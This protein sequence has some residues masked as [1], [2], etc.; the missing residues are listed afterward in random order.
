M[1]LVPKELYG[2]CAVFSSL[3]QRTSVSLINICYVEAFLRLL[4]LYL[5]FFGSAS[6]FMRKA[7]RQTLQWHQQFSSL[8][9][10][11]HQRC[12]ILQQPWRATR[13]QI[14]YYAGDRSDDDLVVREYEQQGADKGTRR[15]VDSE[16]ELTKLKAHLKA[17][18]DRLDQELAEMKEGPF[19]PNSEFMQSLPESE[20]EAAIDTMRKTGQTFMHDPGGVDMDKID[21]E[22]KESEASAEQEDLERFNEIMEPEVILKPP[23]RDQIYVRAFNSAVKAFLHGAPSVEKSA[24][25]WKTYQRCRRHIPNFLGLVPSRAWKILWESQTEVMNSAS[26]VKLLAEDM[27]SQSLPLSSDQILTYIRSLSSIGEVSA[28]IEHWNNNRSVLGP[29]VE[30][31]PQFF[32]LGVQLYSDNDDPV[33]AQKLAFECLDHGTFADASILVPVIA[34]WARAKT[35][36]D[37]SLKA[38]TCY[39]R[40]K[41]ELGTS[42]RAQDY[43]TISS[44]LLS[45]NLP[46]MALAVFKD[47]L[48]DR[49]DA[50]SQHGSLSSFRTL[51]GQVQKMQSAAIT[52]RDVSKIS[53]AALTVLPRFLQNKYFF[54]SWIKNL[55]GRGEIEAAAQVVE[56]MYER[57]VRPDAKHLNGIV[58]AWFR[59]GRKESVQKAEQMAWAMINARIDFVHSRR[60]QQ[61]QEKIHGEHRN[62]KL[63]PLFIRRTVPSATI[64][65]FSILLLHYTRG[66]NE[67]ASAQLMDKMTREALIPPNSFIYNHWMYAA[68]RSHNIARVWSHYQDMKANRVRADLET[69]A[70]LWDTAK[71][72]WDRSKSAHFSLFPSARALFK[73]MVQWTVAS[74]KHFAV[75]KSDPA[76]THHDPPDFSHDLYD[77]IIRVFC[78]SNDLRGVLCALHGLEHF[79]KQDPDPDTTRIVVICIARLLPPD[80]PTE[81]STSGI[82]RLAA[83]RRGS[84]RRLGSMRNALAAVHNILQIVTDQRAVRLMEQEEATGDVDFQSHSESTSLSQSPPRLQQ[85]EQQNVAQRRQQPTPATEPT[86]PV[87]SD[88]AAALTP[89]PVDLIN[90]DPTVAKQ[91]RLDVLSDLIVVVLKQM[92]TWGNATTTTTTAATGKTTTPNP[93]VKKESQVLENNDPGGYLNDTVAS[94]DSEADEARRERALSATLHNEIHMVGQSMGLASPGTVHEGDGQPRRKY[95]DE[96]DDDGS[97]DAADRQK[98]SDDF[99]ADANGSADAAA[100]ASE[101]E[102]D[103]D[104][105]INLSQRIDFRWQG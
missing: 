9:K 43:E 34:A 95:G 3:H 84:R 90:A 60:Q 71:L 11:L 39:L 65:T 70:C 19:G 57:G 100:A 46:D 7:C 55:I 53:L 8:P 6:S 105:D 63:H 99:I 18:L 58:G 40:F 48:L 75:S 51:V 41:A 83:G 1:P 15:R 20:R 91:F 68:L 10:L 77:Q 31:A 24:A 69:F 64:E 23:S 5:S 96:G 37:H 13:D 54:A 88:P 98:L 22:V 101:A 29:D 45:Q 86:E 17:K 72:Q 35:M 87:G 52:E 49:I 27:L 42:I 33:T 78:L 56:L 74:N 21:Q 38:W 28:A 76:S 36:S 80:L 62:R 94:E 93:V 26:N 30:I 79:Y 4:R 2:L 32:S 97:D 81:T 67:S 92:M 89:N 25:L 47:M 104:I 44:A 102:V 16:A 61:Q 85:E 12:G 59:N 73:E 66:R 50:R 14:R 103:V 82:R